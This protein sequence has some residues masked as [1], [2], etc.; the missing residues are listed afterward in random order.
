MVGAQLRSLMAGVQTTIGAVAEGFWAE[1]PELQDR[2]LRVITLEEKV[3]IHNAFP[4]RRLSFD[5]R[6]VAGSL[7]RLASDRQTVSGER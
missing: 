3:T 4:L 1:I 5:A 6:T 2:Y 7:I